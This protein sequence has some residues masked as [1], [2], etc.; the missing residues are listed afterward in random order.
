MNSCD[1]S[2]NPPT[3]NGDAVIAELRALLASVFD[4]DSAKITASIY[5]SDLPNWSSL[6]FVVLHMGIEKRFR[7]T[8]DPKMALTA[9][10]VQ[11]LAAMIK[12]RIDDAGPRD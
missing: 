1:G 7:I 11:Q 10:T 3:P 6:N 9:E 2:A 4:T 8:L 5:L 12:R